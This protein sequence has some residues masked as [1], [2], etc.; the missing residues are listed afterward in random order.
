[1]ASNE[2][3]LAEIVSMIRGLDDRLRRHMEEEEGE[4]H[5]T[6]RRIDALAQSFATYAE[7]NDW[8]KAFPNGD[9]I[10]HCNHHLIVIEREQE[11]I[12]LYKSI[13]KSVAQ[14]GVLGLLAWAAVHLWTAFLQGP[15]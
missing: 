15:K 1:M 12:E 2:S 3:L 5:E 11:R 9:P 13:R 14:W 7:K 8:S 4:I 6:A 10:G